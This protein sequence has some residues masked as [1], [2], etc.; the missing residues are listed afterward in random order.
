[1][2]F[3]QHDPSQ[4]LNYLIKLKAQHS[5]LV[6][7]RQVQNFKKLRFVLDGENLFIGKA[8]Y[9]VNLR[10]KSPEVVV[11]KETDC[12]F[13]IVYPLLYHFLQLELVDG[14]FLLFLGLAEGVKDA[15]C[16]GCQHDHRINNVEGQEK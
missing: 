16:Q 15:C 13:V 6:I 14:D 1:M 4:S 2:L 9:Q 5:L 10:N 3:A 7:D 11:R 12:L 8:I